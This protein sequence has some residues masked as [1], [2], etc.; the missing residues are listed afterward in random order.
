MVQLFGRVTTDAKVS[1]TNTGK[2]V[3]NF[4]IALNDD[5]RNKQGEKVQQVTFINCAYWV[6]EGIAAFLTKGK[7]VELFCR[8]FPTAWVNKEGE[9]VGSIN[10]NVSRLVLHGGGQ[11][12]APVN[13]RKDKKGKKAAT[14][15]QEGDDLPF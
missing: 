7:Q 5:Y 6:N 10:A 14:A 12:M 8:L 9:A 4:S 15:Q 3:V 13:N 2:K 1:E 11:S